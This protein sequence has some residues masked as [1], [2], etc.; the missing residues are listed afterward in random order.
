MFQVLGK[1]LVKVDTGRVDWDQ[2]R[3][4]AGKAEELW[5]GGPWRQ[6]SQDERCPVCPGLPRVPVEQKPVKS[7][8]SSIP[9]WTLAPSPW[10]IQLKALSHPIHL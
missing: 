7:V 3:E 6:V 10:L 8:A 1:Y 9:K 4:L 2:T 5:M